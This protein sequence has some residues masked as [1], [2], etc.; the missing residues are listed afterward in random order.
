V[1]EGGRADAPT[2]R[3]SDG[4]YHT[5]PYNART[6][7]NR[8]CPGHRGPGPPIRHTIVPWGPGPPI[9]VRARACVRACRVR[10][11]STLLSGGRDPT[12][13]L[14]V[15]ACR[16]QH[17]APAGA[18]DHR[19]RPAGNWQSRS[20]CH[21]TSTALATQAGP[22]PIRVYSGDLR[23]PRHELGRRGVGFERYRARTGSSLWMRRATADAFTGM[24]PCCRYWYRI[25]V[26]KYIARLA[27]LAERKALNLVVVGS[28]PTSGG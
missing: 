1:R 14:R 23:R 10:E 26:K 27:Q 3:A 28:S 15:G 17:G 25:Y 18:I 12:G 24:G 2:R 5:H 4:Q 20:R 8:P 16:W 22:S 13:R 9:P 7:D 6:L 11:E 19:D 21:W